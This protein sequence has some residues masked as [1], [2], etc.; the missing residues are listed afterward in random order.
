MVPE[1]SPVAQL[2]RVWLKGLGERLVE[3]VMWSCLDD[4][5]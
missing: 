4:A 5:G 1:A 3:V 2:I